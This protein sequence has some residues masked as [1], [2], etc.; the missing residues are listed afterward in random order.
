MDNFNVNI[1]EALSEAWSALAHADPFVFY[2]IIGVVLVITIAII[3]FTVL[4]VQSK[5]IVFT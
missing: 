3:S 5:I 1:F 4:L 2:S